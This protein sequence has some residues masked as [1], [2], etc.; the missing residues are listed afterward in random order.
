MHWKNV[1]SHGSKQIKNISIA[2]ESSFLIP[3][4]LMWHFLQSLGF[5]SH[6]LS[7]LLVHFLL[8]SLSVSSL[9]E[10][11]EPIVECQ[12]CETEVSPSQ[13]GGSSGDLG[14]ISSFSS[15]ASSSH[16]TSS[17]TSLSAIHS[18]GSS[19]RGAGPLKGKTSGT[20]PADFA[21]PSSR[22][23]PGKLRCRQ[24]LQREPS[25]GR[26]ADVLISHEEIL[27]NALPRAGEISASSSI[28]GKEVP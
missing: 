15:K 2:S 24:V 18:S 14:D 19:G 8:A 1:C 6:H 17:G 16:H 27:G 3:T 26:A 9:Q 25:R 20:E 12:E 21:L 4:W 5:P 28:V 7:F 11:E 13:T 23:G 22:G 10:T